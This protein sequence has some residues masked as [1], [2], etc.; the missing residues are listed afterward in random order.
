MDEGR[1]NL[2]LLRR[3]DIDAHQQTFSH[4]WNPRSEISGAHMSRMA[5]LKRAG[6]SFVNLA[7]GKE[8]FAY[9][10]HHYEEEWIYVLEGRGVALIDGVESEVGP[11]DFLAFP[12]GIAHLMRNPFD[13]TLTY[14]MGGENRDHEVA[15][16]PALNKRMLRLEGRVVVYDLDAGQPLG[17]LA[18]D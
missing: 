4:P 6:V 14:L 3:A 5:G 16:F 2:Y 9:H 1:P 18:E 17:P 13:T 11:G 8:S 15:D 7:P 12:T 10:A